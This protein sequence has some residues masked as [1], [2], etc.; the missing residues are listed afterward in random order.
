MPS[1]PVLDSDL[2]L[3]QIEQSQIRDAVNHSLRRAG[4]QQLQSLRVEV[5]GRNVRLRGCLPSYYLRQLAFHAV[6]AIPGIDTIEDVI[7]IA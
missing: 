1:I 5:N 3:A 2:I 4:Y 7:D 6:Q